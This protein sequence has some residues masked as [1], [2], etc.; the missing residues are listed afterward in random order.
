MMLAINKNK[1]VSQEADLI[2]SL[3]ERHRVQ[4]FNFKC[5]QKINLE[6]KK[7]YC[8][9]SDKNIIF[10]VQGYFSW[11]L[12]FS[13]KDEWVEH[14]IAGI[15]SVEKALA[16]FEGYNNSYVFCAS[17]TE[18]YTLH[19]SIEGL[20]FNRTLLQACFFESIH[21][22]SS[23]IAIMK[24]LGRVG[25]TPQ[26]PHKAERSAYHPFHYYRI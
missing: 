4:L 26:I 7:F 11:F 23:I 8:F 6:G 13:L 19:S 1:E 2:C 9:S 24:N 20:S 10:K 3:V 17:V 5:R 18:G 14:E 16:G 21:I 12:K 15:E 25:I 22:K